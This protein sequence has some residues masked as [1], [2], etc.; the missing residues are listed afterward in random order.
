MM[1][2]TTTS[3][4]ATVTSMP[5]FCA[6]EP[7][8]ELFTSAIDCLTPSDSRYAARTIFISWLCVAQI[9]R[10][11][12]GMPSSCK[13]ISSA[14]SPLQTL[15]SGKRSDAFF[16]SWSSL[17]MMTTFCAALREFAP[18]NLSKPFLCGSIILS[19]TRVPIL[20]APIIAIFR[21]SC[22]LEPHNS[23]IFGTYSFLLKIPSVQPAK[24]SVAPV[25]SDGFPS[26]SMYDTNMGIS[27][28]FLSSKSFE[29]AIA[30]PFITVTREICICESPNVTTLLTAPLSTAFTIASAASTSG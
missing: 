27:V 30:L 6:I 11:N 24:I 22:C 3:F 5:S 29:P 10:S 12:D 20:P 8:A 18:K 28:T 1:E 26:N 16:V 9:A 7:N 25:G 23:R 17:S 21:S 13:K 2:S 15:A 19:A 14:A 4:K